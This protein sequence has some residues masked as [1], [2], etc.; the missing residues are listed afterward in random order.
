MHLAW[1][2]CTN[3]QH[4]EESDFVSQLV[5]VMSRTVEDFMLWATFCFSTSDTLSNIT[6]VTTCQ[7]TSRAS[8]IQQ[9]IMPVNTEQ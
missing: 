1:H 3:S 7:R 5:H 8:Q 2:H 6:H 4:A 9:G